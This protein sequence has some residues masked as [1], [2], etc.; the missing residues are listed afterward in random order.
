MSAR[1]YIDPAD[2]QAYVRFQGAGFSMKVTLD[3]NGTIPESLTEAS[4]LTN[5]A[6]SESS[7]AT[8]V[9]ALSSGGSQPPNQI[10][11]TLSG[12][13]YDAT[14]FMGH[15]TTTTVALTANRLY[16]VPIR[17][18]NDFTIDSVAVYVT[19]SAAGNLRMGI[20][21]MKAN[22]LPGDLVVDGG[23]TSSG[24]T[25][26]RTRYLSEAVLPAGVYWLA[27]ISDATP[28]VRAYTANTGALWGS[29]GDGVYGSH[30]RY[31]GSY[32]ALPDPFPVSSLIIGSDAAPFLYVYRT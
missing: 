30:V 27:L 1:I 17:F 3:E 31:S 8:A 22:G 24:S 10:K 29:R 32:G 12:F 15:V 13:Q 28:T 9:S 16:A 14:T 2:G 19:S 26:E 6:D 4:L 11:T 21:E 25:G 23:A 5:L 7:V 20:Y 18:E